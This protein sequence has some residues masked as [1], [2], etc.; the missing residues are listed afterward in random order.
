MSTSGIHSN[1]ESI[2]SPSPVPSVANTGAVAAIDAGS[3][4]RRAAARRAIFGLGA[5]A[6]RGDTRA[7]RAVV[8]GSAGVSDTNAVLTILF[9][10]NVVLRDIAMGNE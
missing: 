6:M 2:P 7:A 3:A 10:I 1:G 9:V 8:R 5:V 4:A